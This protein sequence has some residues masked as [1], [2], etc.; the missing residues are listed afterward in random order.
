MNYLYLGIAI[1]AEVMATTMLKK[2][3]AFTN[4]VPSLIVVGGYLCAFYF[5]S[6]TL[7]SMH[8]GIVYAIWSGLGMVLIAIAG[9]IFYQQEIDAAGILG[10]AFILM[11]VLVI[12]LFS[13][14]TNI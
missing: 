5:L 8:L 3:E 6:L 4:I 13:K 9:K 14:S 12:N 1:V 10:I 11:G 7:K 2:A